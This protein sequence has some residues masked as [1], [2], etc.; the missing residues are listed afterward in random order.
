MGGSST[1]ATGVDR[2]KPVRA[3]AV[4][5]RCA[6]TTPKPG[7]SVPHAPPAS[8]S[9]KLHDSLQLPGQRLKC[10]TFGHSGYFPLRTVPVLI[11]PAIDLRGGQCVRLRQGDYRQ[12]TVFGSD[13][14]A[15]ARHWVG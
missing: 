2:L 8:P 11:L 1:G 3:S 10:D 12:E 7:E 4:K 13:P 14:A 6:K 5:S 15:M 9:G